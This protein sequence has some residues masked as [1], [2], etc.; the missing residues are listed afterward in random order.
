MG[1]EF[2]VAISFVMFVLLLLYLGL[3]GKVAKVLDDRA[4]AIRREIEEAKRLRDEAQTMLA[5][6]QRRREEASK[7]AEE[8]TALARKE[9]LFFAEETRKSLSDQLARRAKSAEE[10]IARAEAQAITEIRSKA[11]DAAV[12]A[13]QNLISDRLSAKK[14]EQLVVSSIAEI[15]TK[16]N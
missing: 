4:E 15:K 14:A 1:P 3:P 12:N 9:A 2:W 13:A 10:K 8:I 6:Y 11:V 7:E 5:D 16:L